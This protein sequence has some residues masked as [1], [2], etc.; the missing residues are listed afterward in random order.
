MHQKHMRSLTTNVGVGL[1][2]WKSPCSVGSKV[3]L[4]LGCRR[5]NGGYVKKKKD[6]MAWF[7]PKYELQRILIAAICRVAERWRHP[8][9]PSP[10]IK[11]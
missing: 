9:H 10:I 5:Q 6:K 11:L 8:K 4:R 1:E 2:K 3:K 7:N